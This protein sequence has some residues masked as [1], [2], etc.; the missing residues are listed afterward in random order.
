MEQVLMQLLAG[1]IAKYPI[2]ASILLIVGVLRAVN[3]PLFALLHAF[4]DTTE[5]KKDDE[6]LAKAESSKLYKGVAFV[7][8]WLGSIKLKK[9]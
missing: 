1:F 4:V 5:S 7:L 9:A 2:G 6:L 8:D 3:K